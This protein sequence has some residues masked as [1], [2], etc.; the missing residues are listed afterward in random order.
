M[1]CHM[2]SNNCIRSSFEQAPS[3]LA[4]SRRGSNNIDNFQLQHEK[5][6]MVSS[7]G[8]SHLSIITGERQLQNISMH[9]GT[10]QA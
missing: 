9:D 6:V 3:L 2:L 7:F 1:T 5:Q 4:V 10:F 8:Q